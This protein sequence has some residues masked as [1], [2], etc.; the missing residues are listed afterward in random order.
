MFLL[1]IDVTRA[2][3]LGNLPQTALK[4]L[5]AQIIGLI[6]FNNLLHICC[7]LFSYSARIFFPT[8]RGVHG[9]LLF[10]FFFILKSI[11]WENNNLKRKKSKNFKHFYSL[12]FTFTDYLSEQFLNTISKNCNDRYFIHTA[13][14]VFSRQALISIKYIYSSIHQNKCNFKHNQSNF[15]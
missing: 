9:K 10:G 11:I 14:K 4:H 13:F 15:Q 1:S 7:E 6:F 3:A 12:S 2:L 8:I 5:F